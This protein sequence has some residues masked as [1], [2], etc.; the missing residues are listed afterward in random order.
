RRGQGPNWSEAARACRDGDRIT[1]DFE[2]RI[3]GEAFEGGKSE[4]LVV[5]LGAGR[6]LPDSEQGVVGAGTGENREFDLRFPDDYQAKHLAGKSA[7]F[8]VIVRKV[9]ES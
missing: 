6:L 7:R 4:N 1:I 3:G 2:G 9:E 8:Q 5:V